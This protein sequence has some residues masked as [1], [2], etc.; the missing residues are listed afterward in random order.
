[1]Y[2]DFTV[3]DEICGEMEILPYPK[4]TL[5]PQEGTSVKSVREIRPERIFKDTEGNIILDI[6]QKIIGYIYFRNVHV[7]NELVKLHY[8][9]S[10]DK[11]Q[12]F[13][14]DI[15]K[16]I[17]VDTY[18]IVPNDGKVYE[19]HFTFHEFRFV[20]LEGF[21]QE[22]SIDDFSG[23]VLST[24]LETI[25]DLNTN[26]EKVNQLQNDIY[27]E[28]IG[29]LLEIPTKRSHGNKRQGWTLDAQIML[30]TAAFNFQ[31]YGFFGKWLKDL[32]GAQKEYD[33]AVPCVVPN[34]LNENIF[35]GKS[36]TCAGWGDAA[37]IIPWELYKAYGNREI[38]E[39][40]YDSM[41]A[42]IDYVRSEGDNEYLWSPEVQ[43]ILEI[44]LIATAYYAYSTKLFAKTAK[45]F[46][47]MTDYNEYSNLFTNIQE[48]FY[49]KFIK[50]KIILTDYG[51]T[52]YALA[53]HFGILKKKDTSH[54]VKH[55]VGLINA[56]NDHINTDFWAT[57]FVYNVLTDYGYHDLAYNIFFNE[58]SSFTSIGK[59][60]YRTVGGIDALEPG[61]SKSII[62]P[63]PDSRIGNSKCTL[64][65][66][67]GKIE[68]DWELKDCELHI[69]INI[70]ANTE[71]L[72]ILPNPRERT[73]LVKQIRQV[74]DNT[75]IFENKKSKLQLN[76]LYNEREIHIRDDVTF[77]IGSGKYEFSYIMNKR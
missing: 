17:Q 12:N 2:I 5:I 60:I 21:N 77:T 63:K 36:I 23:I 49:K 46:R 39:Q 35:E 30:P 56:N 15:S 41:K 67:Q 40:Q 20:K 72:V 74:T 16:E 76:N 64:M 26:N 13:P 73:E 18:R 7:D 29:N 58:D 52:V 31:I 70:P 75:A 57:P 59:W 11:D 50:D 38:L 25:C 22:V 34:V 4:T 42:W 14:T 61:Y 47:R 44:E 33:G 3:E 45:I 28:L 48:E 66:M 6:G 53:L 1:M 32:A 9:E 62:A 65:S 71:A 43:S 55:L 27:W 69:M 8:A 19:P 10:L 51:Q 54:A 24:E 37:V 68:C